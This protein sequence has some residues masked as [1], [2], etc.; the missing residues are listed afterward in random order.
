MVITFLIGNGFDLNLG[1]NTQYTDFYN[2]YFTLDSAKDDMLVKQI[3]S[4]YENWADLEM[5]LAK[6]ASN[7]KSNQIEEFLQSKE[8]MEDALIEYL[9]RQEN[10]I[11]FSEE[12]SAESFKS[13]VVSFYN[14]L[15]TQWQEEYQN[16]RRSLKESITYQFVNF[17]YT[18]TLDRL[19]TLCKNKYKPL[20]NRVI[21]QT[22]YP[23][24][25]REPLHIHGTL[26]D[27]L[28]LGI[29]SVDQI[30]NFENRNNP[31]LSAYLVKS[32]INKALGEKRMERFC[33]MIDKSRYLFLYGL[34]WGDSDQ[35]WWK[36]IIN[37]LSK[38]PNNRLILCAYAK[39]VVPISA[40]KKLRIADKKRSF[41]VK[42][43]LGDE[44]V[45][46]QIEDRIQVIINPNIFSLDGTHTHAET[47]PSNTNV[48]TLSEKELVGAM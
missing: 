2:Y 24:T 25:I 16:L 18:N 6:L 15:N 13:S 12:L 30:N 34:S 19:V 43:G 31:E 42:Q 35:T 33:N 7:L 48:V 1:L 23:D 4:N 37:W 8:R 9:R 44:D 26:K 41:F 32:N 36:Y 46:Q 17:N 14:I 40:S 29:D 21:A 47:K 39:G 38:N 11:E 5:G 22:T 3:K 28:I 10:R 45:Y 27:N 20:S